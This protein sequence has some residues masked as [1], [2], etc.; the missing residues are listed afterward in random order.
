L[1]ERHEGSMMCRAKQSLW[2]S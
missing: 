2:A 1:A